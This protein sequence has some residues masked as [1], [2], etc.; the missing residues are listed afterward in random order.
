MKGRPATGPEQARKEG[1]CCFE[2]GF[3]QRRHFDTEP[4]YGHVRANEKSA[5]YSGKFVIQDVF[6]SGEN[7]VHIPWLY[8]MHEAASPPELQGDGARVTVLHLCGVR[9]RNTG[10]DSN[11]TWSL[12]KNPARGLADGR[13]RGGL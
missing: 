8:T 11:I 4:K 1:P 7:C 6:T 5:H 12:R 2:T 9:F 13:K 10:K 3:H